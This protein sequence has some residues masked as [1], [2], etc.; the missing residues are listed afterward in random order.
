M[1]KR[2]RVKD[3]AT[4]VSDLSPA[5]DE[6]PEEKQVSTNGVAQQPSSKKRR[7]KKVKEKIQEDEGVGLEQSDSKKKRKKTVKQEKGVKTEANGDVVEKKKP[8][9]KTKEEKE[10]EAMPLALR[11]IGHKLFIGAHVSGAG[12]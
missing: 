8:K 10:A 7:V 9:R 3:A 5:P 11:T 12:G 4:E 1:P 6:L 2:K